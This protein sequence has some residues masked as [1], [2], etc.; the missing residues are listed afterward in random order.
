[1]HNMQII[2]FQSDSYY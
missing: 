2:M 1:M